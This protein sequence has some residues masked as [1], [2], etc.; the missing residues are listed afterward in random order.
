MEIVTVYDRSDL[1]LSAIETINPNIPTGEVEVVPAR[2]EVLSEA[3]T[4]PFYIN[5]PVE[6][7]EQLRALLQRQR[8]DPG[9][10]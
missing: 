9:R 5:E 1:I 6:V 7:D 3:Q 8:R 4:P 2:V 10:W